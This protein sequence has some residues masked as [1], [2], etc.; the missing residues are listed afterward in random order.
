MVECSVVEIS[1]KPVEV[2]DDNRFIQVARLERN[3]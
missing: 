1:V 3:Q 2:M